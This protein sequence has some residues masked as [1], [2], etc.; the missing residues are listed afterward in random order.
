MLFV[1]AAL[2]L[3][4]MAML[5]VLAAVVSA[6]LTAVLFIFVAFTVYLLVMHQQY[7]HIP[8]PKG[9]NKLI[10]STTSFCL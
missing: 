1:L 6:V 2:L 3:W 10:K 7:A 5:A 9:A 4:N 8:Q